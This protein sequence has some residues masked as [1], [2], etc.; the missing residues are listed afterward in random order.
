MDNFLT[1]QQTE[2]ILLKPRL[3]IDLQTSED[4]GVLLIGGIRRG[5]ESGL[6]RG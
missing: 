2:N 6:Y 4:E 3:L 5:N 1:K